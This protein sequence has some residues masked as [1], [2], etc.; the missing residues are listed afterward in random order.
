[1]VG[2][3]PVRP[4]QSSINLAA[5]IKQLA[6]TISERR[7]PELTPNQ[8]YDK[9]WTLLL[10]LDTKSKVLAHDQLLPPLFLH[11]FSCGL[12]ACVLLQ[13]LPEVPE[14]HHANHLA[15]IQV[16]FAGHQHATGSVLH[17]PPCQDCFADDLPLLQA[18]AE[19]SQQHKTADGTKLGQLVQEW[20][21]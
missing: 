19:L 1:M 11:S 10:D 14:R 7:C 9:A 6:T 13:V 12:T 20:L 17:S 18:C 2:D 5:G 3:Q 16:R 15:T 4:Q 21:R 8:A